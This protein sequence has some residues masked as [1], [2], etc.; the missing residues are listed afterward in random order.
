MQDLADGYMVLLNALIKNGEPNPQTKYDYYLFAEAGG[1][2]E[3]LEWI[4]ASETI[5]K[6]MHKKGLAKTAEVRILTDDECRQNDLV[7]G[8]D[9]LDTDTELA[10]VGSRPSSSLS[11]LFECVV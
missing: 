8:K 2:D 11:V 4:Q 7:M 6:V 5:G 9:V 3:E 10:V 1:D